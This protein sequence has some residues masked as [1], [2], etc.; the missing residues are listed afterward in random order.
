M[1]LRPV[2]ALG[3][4]AARA[5]RPVMVVLVVVVGV[6]LAAAAGA[7]GVE[8]NLLGVSGQARRG[9]EQGRQHA[10]EIGQESQR[11]PHGSQA[12]NISC[13]LPILGP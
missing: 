5:A 12:P 10:Q 1:T 6:V 3:A 8:E 4:A 2:L 9:G 11:R 7:G 13:R